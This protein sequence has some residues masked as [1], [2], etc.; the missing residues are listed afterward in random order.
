MIDS[1]LVVGQGGHGEKRRAGRE[2]GVL[3]GGRRRA[4]GQT[5]GEDDERGEA[6]RDAAALVFVH[7]ERICFAASSRARKR[8]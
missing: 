4:A 3:G 2:P 6:G 8:G 1:L 7:G 5:E